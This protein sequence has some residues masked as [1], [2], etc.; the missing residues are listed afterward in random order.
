MLKR[1]RRNRSSAAIRGLIRE[2]QLTSN[3]LIQPLFLVN[4]QGIKEEIPSLPNNFRMSVDKALEEVGECL[5]LGIS[6]FILFLI[7]E[8]M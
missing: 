6:N 7:R 2:T 1:P 5:G 3:H 8:N 4:G